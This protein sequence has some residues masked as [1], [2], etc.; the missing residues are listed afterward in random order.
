MKRGQEHSVASTAACASQ[1]LVQGNSFAESYNL[2]MLKP[3]PGHKLD[4][5]E[6]QW[7]AH[8]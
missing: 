4:Q 1:S 8:L 2:R 7:D 3:N 5:E 6:L